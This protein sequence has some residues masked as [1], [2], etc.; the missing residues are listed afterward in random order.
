MGLPNVT[1][2]G[3]FTI[4]SFFPDNVRSVQKGLGV[5]AH[6]VGHGATGRLCT[7]QCHLDIQDHRWSSADLEY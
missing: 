6:P 3:T 2:V 5:L 1:V 7:W 4:G